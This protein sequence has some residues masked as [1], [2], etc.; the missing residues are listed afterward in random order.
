MQNSIISKFSSTW[1]PGHGVQLFTVAKIIILKAK[2]CVSHLSTNLPPFPTREATSKGKIIKLLSSII[3]CPHQK[4]DSLKMVSP[5]ISNKYIQLLELFDSTGLAHKVL[6]PIVCW[7]V[8]SIGIRQ[9]NFSLWL[10]LKV[11]IGRAQ[12]HLSKVNKN[13]QRGN[14]FVAKS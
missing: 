14:L 12:D 2:G 10:F 1:W 9:R 4:R 13:F 5:Q 11:F 3:K 8:L 6:I 7:D